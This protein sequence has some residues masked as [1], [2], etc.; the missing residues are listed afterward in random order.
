[1]ARLRTL[2]RCHF[3]SLTFAASLLVSACSKSPAARGVGHEAAY[4]D[5]W[6]PPYIDESEGDVPLKELPTAESLRKFPLFGASRPVDLERPVDWRQDPYQSRS[7]ILQLHAWRFMPPL[8]AGYDKYRDPR[9]LRLAADFA[10]DWLGAH[11]AST[12]KEGL[13]WYDMA[14]AARATYLAYLVRAGGISKVLNDRESETMLRA[15][16]QHAEWLANKSN[17]MAKHNHGLYSDVALLAV[18]KTLDRLPSCEEWRALARRRSVENF[19]ATVTPSGVH[20]EHTPSYHFAIIRLLERRLSLDDDAALRKKL[21]AMKEVAAWYLQ[22]DGRLPQLGDTHDDLA[23]S[24]AV[25]AAAQLNGARFFEDAGL[26]SVKTAGA[27]LLVTGARHSNVHKHED[28]LSFVLS[29]SGRRLLI[30]PG[31]LSYNKN[32]TRAFLTSAPAHNAF[33]VDETYVRSKKVPRLSLRSH[34]EGG[35]WYA[36]RGENLH[37]IKRVG[38]ERT[39][40][41]SPGKV[42]LV[43]D[44]FVTD[45]K[46]HTLSRYFHFAP[47][48]QATPAPRGA[49]ASVPGLEAELFDA[50]S[51]PTSV[52]IV[53]GRREGALQGLVSPSEDVLLDAS[54]VEMKTPVGPRSATLL[55]VVQ[56]SSGARRKYAI[57][58]RAQGEL[59]LLVDGQ[60][61]VVRDADARLAITV[62]ATAD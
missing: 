62:G 58:G 11:E 15:V 16:K 47:D 46:E 7:W 9:M 39:W 12:K 40:L 21:A 8:L 4:G 35:G 5:G 17:Y 13:V 2:T 34:G 38:H 49:H 51:L 36:V 19:E 18:C 25:A 1:M 24:W 43:V 57:L 37:T 48:V 6:R 28:D 50:S 56:L 26:Y 53:K 27:Q 32:D 42:L 23:P 60:R 45:G 3:L 41:Y 29:E 20:R 14:V 31:F 30:D 22:P 52:E 59:T 44:D 33:L 10:L 54:A 61:L 55:S